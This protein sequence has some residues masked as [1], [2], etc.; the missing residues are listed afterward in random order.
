MKLTT[1]HQIAFKVDLT[2]VP[3]LS[4]LDLVVQARLVVVPQAARFACVRSFAVDEVDVDELPQAVVA[5][6]FV[7]ALQIAASLAGSPVAERLAQERADTQRAAVGLDALV[8][9]IAA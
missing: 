9:Q 5:P 1:N 2:D 7:V 6:V 4:S 8:V 3:C